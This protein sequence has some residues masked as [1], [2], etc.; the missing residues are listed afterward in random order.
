[1]QGSTPSSPAQ[2]GAPT[3]P[4]VATNGVKDQLEGAGEVGPGQHPLRPE[5][6]PG[7]VTKAPTRVQ[8]ALKDVPEGLGLGEPEP[9]DQHLLGVFYEL[10]GH[11]RFARVAPFPP[12]DP[13]LSEAFQRD[14]YG[15]DER[16]PVHGREVRDD[17][18]RPR[19]ADE[20][21]AG[22]AGEEDDG[23]RLV[24][25][26]R[27]CRLDA[28]E[29]GERGLYEDEI[30]LEPLGRHDRLPPVPG[31]SHHAMA[32]ALKLV[33]QAGRDEVLGLHDEYLERLRAST[34]EPHRSRVNR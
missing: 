5:D 12:E 3:R 14:F 18:R 29:P 27:A 23:Y 2:G 16:L 21:G 34:I 31:Q 20:L 4:Q 7:G 10:P 17:T 6:C 24:G 26:D 28:V 19:A 30:R 9:R 13:E 8:L 15:R 33:L 1:M 11:R 25:D 32:K 22:I